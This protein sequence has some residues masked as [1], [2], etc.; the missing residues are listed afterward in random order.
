MAKS[1]GF[2]VP[3]GLLALAAD[4]GPGDV[5]GSSYFNTTDGTIKTWDG[6]QWTGG[7]G[8]APNEVIVQGSAPTDTNVELWVNPNEDDPV[9]LADLDALHLPIAGG[10]LTGPAF[11]QAAPVEPMG[12]A[13]KD[14]VD[15]AVLA[16]KDYVDS[17]VRGRNRIIN[18]D[19][20][21][22]QRGFTSTTTNIGYGFDRWL[23]QYGP[24]VVTYSAQTPALG[25]LPESAEAY[26]RIVTTGQAAAGDYA[27]LQQKIEGVR[28]LSGKTVTISFWAKAAAGTP[29]VSVETL[30]LFG[31]G[32]SPSPI[33]Y[34]D[35]GR[36][37]LST[38]WTRYSVTATVPSLAGKT[39]G[40]AG[41]D[42]LR[43]YLWTSAGSDYD[44]RCGN[45]G[46]QDATIDFWGV[47]VE[48]G[49]VATPFEQKTFAE[50]LRACQRYFYRWSTP[51]GGA[52]G[53][54][55]FYTTTGVYWT[56]HHPVPMRVVP[57][58]TVVSAPGSINPHGASTAAALSSLAI[59][60]NGT[61]EFTEF[62]GSTSAIG[63][64]GGGALIR[65]TAGQTATID[66]NAEL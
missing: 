7:G 6:A 26:A 22:N 35:F 10:T 56:A 61:P 37:T 63:V 65:A 41:D 11:V 62:N 44:A 45:M 12:F 1:H 13:N 52:M 8:V 14:Y 49:P 17:V 19:F 25:E 47:Q 9:L 15:S 43:L 24:A 58:V 5:P 48:E 29:K 2:I 32:G 60:G 59:S 18:G 57:V 16:N 55:Y 4:P 50:E 53:T 31:T 54:G 64:A 28:T 40:T 51:G 36:I 46:V 33:A 42:C 30:Q 39:I 66:F 21:V 3:I 38:A 20:S 23:L 34:T 27:M